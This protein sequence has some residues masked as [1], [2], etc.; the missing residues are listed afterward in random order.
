MLSWTV[1]SCFV[2]KESYFKLTG[3]N[4]HNH[5]GKLKNEKKM[6]EEAKRY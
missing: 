6:V 4:K 2:L 3:K 1:L 5:L